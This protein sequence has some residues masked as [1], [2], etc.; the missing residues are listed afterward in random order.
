MSESSSP[1]DSDALELKQALA[2]F[3]EGALDLFDDDDDSEL[4]ENFCNGPA[5]DGESIAVPELCGIEETDSEL[6]RFTKELVNSIYGGSG[7][8]ESNSRQ[9]AE[10]FIVFFVGRNAFGI[11]LQHAREIIRHPK[12]AALPW[13]PAW[14]RGV[15][16]VRGQIISVTDIRHLSG[17]PIETLDVSEKAIVIHCETKQATT[18]IVA[19]RILGIRC[20]PESQ[21]TVEGVSPEIQAIAKSAARIDGEPVML[22]DVKKLFEAAE[23]AGS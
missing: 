22:I 17:L 20:F 18:S 23:F 21:Q 8:D 9:E 7:H 5:E 13:A 16:N 6:I 3:G 2:A 4:F 10:R 19:N 15:T 14:L 1:L 11:P 12:I